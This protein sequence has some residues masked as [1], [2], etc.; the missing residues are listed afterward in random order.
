[1]DISIMIK[2]FL[3]I[4]VLVI[5]FTAIPCVADVANYENV[6]SKDV[7]ISSKEVRKVRTAGLTKDMSVEKKKKKLAKFCVKYDNSTYESYKDYREK[8]VDKI[9]WSKVDADLPIE[10]YELFAKSFHSL[11]PK[12]VTD[13]TS[14]IKIQ[15]FV[16]YMSDLEINYSRYTI[17]RK[18]DE[19]A[20]ENV[21]DNGVFDT[22][23]IFIKNKW[24]NLIPDPKYYT[25]EQALIKIKYYLEKRGNTK[26]M[27]KKLAQY[28][29]DES[30]LA[31]KYAYAWDNGYLDYTGSSY[32]HLTTVETYNENVLENYI[33][34]ID[35]MKAQNYTSDEI[36]KAFYG[37]NLIDFAKSDVNNILCFLDKE[38][39][40]DWIGRFC[41]IEEKSEFIDEMYKRGYTH[42]TIL[43]FLYIDFKKNTN[44]AVTIIDTMLKNGYSIKK[45]V[46]FIRVLDWDAIN[47]I[48]EEFF[49]AVEKGLLINTLDKKSLEYLI[50]ADAHT[51]SILNNFS[52]N[53]INFSELNDEAIQ[54]IEN[55]TNANELKTTY[56]KKDL[57]NDIVLAVLNSPNIKENKK[58][59]NIKK[60]Q[61]V[62]KHNK[63]HAENLR[64]AG[65]TAGYSM[66]GGAVIAVTWPLC[67]T[68]A[69]TSAIIDKPRQLYY[70]PRYIQAK[71]LNLEIKKVKLQP[72]NL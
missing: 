52:A 30:P 39:S 36:K 21:S 13:K 10:F 5:F 56:T 3:F 32:N 48:P 11:P 31:E 9:D 27:T 6:M 70:V 22:L 47:D 60:L 18:I 68:F 7:E 28:I 49:I 14:L 35:K 62:R 72:L 17:E 53:G 19:I 65:M 34:V 37:N 25:D 71:K 61:A 44:T 1:M 24:I 45:I 12:Y 66:Y 16:E 67:A 15:E 42:R 69:I 64:T 51:V 38:Y 55:K 4:L 29:I 40:K 33:I 57:D 43:E 20:W 46:A 59:S 2:R 26:Y 54:F 63:D 58:V 41:Y 50:N 23:K 8:F